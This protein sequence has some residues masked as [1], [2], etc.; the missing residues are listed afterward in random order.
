[1]KNMNNVTESTVNSIA[2]TEVTALRVTEATLFTAIINTM[3]HEGNRTAAAKNTV[4]ANTPVCFIEYKRMHTS[5][6]REI[7][8]LLSVLPSKD[9]DAITAAENRAFPL[10]KAIFDLSGVLPEQ[11]DLYALVVNGFTARKAKD[12]Q[13]ETTGKTITGKVSTVPV[14][15]STF[16]K[17]VEVLAGQKMNGFAW[18][19][20]LNKFRA[21][22]DAEI[23][24]E[25]KRIKKYHEKKA[26]EAE[27][28]KA[29]AEAAA[30][31]DAKNAR[32]EAI[33]NADRAAAKKSTA[34]K[35]AG[36][37]A[38]A[39]TAVNETQSST[40]IAPVGEAALTIESSNQTTAA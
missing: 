38:A 28:A 32:K 23:E 5:L 21:K 26:A 31:K 1:M 8:A 13:D 3:Y 6:H 19:A 33:A 2:T 20:N 25:N 16:R 29:A 30:K 37:S 15:E 11:S 22:T 34:K 40:Q 39:K 14:S 27:A 36:K 10:L 17:Q 4:E 9:R 18:D 24:R 35:S 7:A 12:E